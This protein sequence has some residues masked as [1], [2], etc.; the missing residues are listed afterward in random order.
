M[1]S[2]PPSPSSACC[3]FCQGQR[4]WRSTRRCFVLGDGAKPDVVARSATRR[5]GLGIFE[6]RRLPAILRAGGWLTATRCKV[7]AVARAALGVASS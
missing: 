2:S 1:M 4:T 5:C 6:E 3:F 7:D